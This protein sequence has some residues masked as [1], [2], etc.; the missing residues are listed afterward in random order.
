MAPAPRCSPH[1]QEQLILSAAA[2][3][4]EQSSLMDFTMSAIAKKAGVSIGS[5]YKH[6]QSKEDVLV[7][8]ATRMF[9][10]LGEKFSQ[11]LKLD[12]STPE[13]VAAVVLMDPS[14]TQCF[15]FDSHLDTLVNCD[16]ILRRASPAWILRMS[17]EIGHTKEL[18]TQIWIDAEA[19]GEL[20]INPAK[21]SIEQLNTG[22]WALHVG[23]TQVVMRQNNLLLDPTELPNLY[24]LA[25]DDHLML[26][27][28]RLLNSYNWRQPLDNTGIERAID[29]LSQ[30]G[31][32]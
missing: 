26:N 18:F 29:A 13:R 22:M 6:V 32:R 17:N 10:R 21:E 23:Y 3:C 2:Q 12:L 20:T 5:L 8:L 24:P 28:Q 1:Q 16:A 19:S 9:Q 11:V 30:H 15:V 25:A 14:K 31:L 7:A 4:I 27:A